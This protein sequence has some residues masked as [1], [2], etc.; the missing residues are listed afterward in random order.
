MP[1]GDKTA[2]P[3]SIQSSIVMRQPVEALSTDLRARTRA[4]AALDPHTRSA[5][6]DGLEARL[7]DKDVDAPWEVASELVD[8]GYQSAELVTVAAAFGGV[9][10]A[11]LVGWMAAKAAVAGLLD[12]IGG[13]LG[14]VVNLVAALRAYTYLDQA[15]LQ[16]VDINQSLETTLQVMRGRLGIGVT[17]HREFAPDL[18]TIEARGG[19]LNQ[20]W[21]HLITNAI[22]AT[23][24]RGELTLRTRRDGAWAVV[25][26]EDIGRGIPDTVR[27]RIF[28]LFFTTKPPGHGAG[29]GLHAEYQSVVH[30][31]G[32]KI[33]VDSRP[34]RTRF[35]IRLPLR[36]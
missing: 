2:T 19:E 14:R 25:E 28:D 21:T 30:G 35:T 16:Q 36:R 6:Q 1:V 5:R 13:G 23:A 22:E 11:S 33:D 10:L 24:D 26:V 17:L 12:A 20:V 7:R 3:I 29:L 18:P 8:L 27:P 15:P 9:P 34:G 31:H 32:G 4:S